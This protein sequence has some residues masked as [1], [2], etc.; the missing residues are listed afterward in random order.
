MIGLSF[1]P[2][3]F[4]LAAPVLAQGPFGKNPPVNYYAQAGENPN[5]DFSDNNL[6]PLS[7]QDTNVSQYLIFYL[8]MLFLVTLIAF[9][10][11]KL[12]PKKNTLPR[13]RPVFSISYHDIK[14]DK[15]TKSSKKSAK[16][17]EERYDKSFSP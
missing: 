10:A 12:E 1:I 14:K 9:M 8:S 11:A 4:I 13:V 16:Q 17:K 2:A 15:K 5:L 7:F 6:N 3:L